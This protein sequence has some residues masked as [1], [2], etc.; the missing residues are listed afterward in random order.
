MS[1]GTPVLPFLLI[2]PGSRVITSIYS[3]PLCIGCI[4]RSTA[5]RPEDVSFHLEAIT[6][7]GNVLVHGLG[8]GRCPGCHE[9]QPLF[10]SA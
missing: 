6:A 7:D 1:S 5:L 3:M 9:A 8:E 10:E 4:A 2:D